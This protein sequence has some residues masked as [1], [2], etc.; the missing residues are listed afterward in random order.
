[1][2]IANTLNVSSALSKRNDPILAELWAVKAKL[3][4]EAGYDVKRLLSKA[5]ETATRLLGASPSLTH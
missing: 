1:M 2:T 3:N 4:A 5:R